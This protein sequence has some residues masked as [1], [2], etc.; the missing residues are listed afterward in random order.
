MIK[1]KLLFTILA[2]MSVH[3]AFSQSAEKRLGIELSGGINEYQGDLGSALF[4]AK[5]PNYQGVGYSLSYYLNP[6]TSNV[7]NP[8]SVAV[9]LAKDYYS[10]RVFPNAIV[11]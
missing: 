8:S 4:F 11:F 2:I 9:L 10:K 3:Q 5:K 7:S 1:G 6:N